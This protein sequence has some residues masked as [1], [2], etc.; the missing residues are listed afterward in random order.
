M[1]SFRVSSDIRKLSASTTD[2][3][4]SYNET[5]RECFLILFIETSVKPSDGDK[6]IAL[7]PGIRIFQT[8]YSPD[9]LIVEIGRGAQSKLK[10]ELKIID[11]MISKS[12]RRNAK[13]NHRKRKSLRR[14][15]ARKERRVHNM[16]DDLHCKTASFLTKNFNHI[17][18]PEFRVAD[19]VTKPNINSVTKRLM[20]RY[21]FC[22]FRERMKYKCQAANVKLDLVDE[23]FT[24]KTCTC[25]GTLNQKLKSEMIFTCGSCGLKI[26]RDHN[27]ARNIYI[28]TMG[29]TPTLTADTA[30]GECLRVPSKTRQLLSVSDLQVRTN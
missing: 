6:E 7:D 17:I 26:L 3:K 5:T 11:E 8:G 18:L 28:K 2:F 21:R 10:Q 24:S 16:V 15:I 9:N 27:G 14:A 1:P 4:I 20:Y 29:A 30:E 25:C 19:M 12:T 22:D 23:S 13:A